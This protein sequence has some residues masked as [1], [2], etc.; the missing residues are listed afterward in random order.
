[1]GPTESELSR[2][3]LVLK[4]HLNCFL[5]HVWARASGRGITDP[6]WLWF[7]RRDRLRSLCPATGFHAARAHSSGHSSPRTPQE[8]ITD[9]ARGLCG[10]FEEAICLVNRSSRRAPHGEPVFAW[11]HMVDCT[12]ATAPSACRMRHHGATCAAHL[13]G[14]WLHGHP[15]PCMWLIRRRGRPS[16]TEGAGG[17]APW[18]LQ[19]LALAQRQVDPGRLRANM[20]NGTNSPWWQTAFLSRHGI[21]KVVP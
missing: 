21:S 14:G 8:D 16:T 18:C 5:S 3:C 4:G 1:M 7:D 2:G 9:P 17:L 12:A 20:T 10:V 13:A 11:A 19:S 6:L 15:R